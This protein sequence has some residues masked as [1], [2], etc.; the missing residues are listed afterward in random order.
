M[1]RLDCRPTDTCPV[2]R[3][4]APDLPDVQHRGRVAGPEEQLRRVAAAEAGVPAALPGAEREDLGGALAVRVHRVGQDR[5]LPALDL[6]AVDPPQQ[7]ADVEPGARLGDV[8]VKH[9][10][11]RFEGFQRVLAGAVGSA[12]N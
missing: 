9:L 12:A 2:A 6:V 8:L 10:D 11:P 7:H 3:R 1:I 4:D 5:H